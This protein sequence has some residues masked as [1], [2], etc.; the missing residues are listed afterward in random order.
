MFFRP[1]TQSFVAGQINIALLFAICAC[2]YLGVCRGSQARAG[3]VIAFAAA[4][5]VWPAALVLMQTG[6]QR[7]LRFVSTA[8]VAGGLLLLVSAAAFGPEMHGDFIASQRAFQ[9]RDREANAE[10]VDFLDPR[11]SHWPA[12]NAAPFTIVART[13]SFLDSASL[14]H[15]VA[16]AWVVVQLLFCTVTVGLLARAARRRPDARE[17][18]VLAF[19]ALVLLPLVLSKVTWAYYGTFLVLP[20][21]LLV[22]VVR[23]SPLA[24]L[25]LL[26]SFTGFAAWE[27]VL[28]PGHWAPGPVQSVMYVLNPATI[29]YILFY[30]L[31]LV[32]L[33][34]LGSR[35]AEAPETRTAAATAAV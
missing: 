33:Y 14:S 3:V 5:K 21:L 22:S 11:I 20:F 28:Y 13:V 35:S 26:F 29:G 34:Q 32:L 12:S 25:T 31:T 8:V 4:I 24:R 27:H 9:D 30:A 18:P 10:G 7:T 16:D 15:A 23:L 2:Y 17:L 1:V 6:R 19:A